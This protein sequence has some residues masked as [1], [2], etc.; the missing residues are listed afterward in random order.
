MCRVLTTITKGSPRP[1]STDQPALP[2]VRLDRRRQRGNLL[3]L[4]HS[5]EWR[6][7]GLAVLFVSFAAAEV[8]H[9]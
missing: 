8:H 3:I 5:D 7:V 9:R 1:N 4:R 2:E 6:A